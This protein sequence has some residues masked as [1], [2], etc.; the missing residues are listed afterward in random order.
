MEVLVFITS[1]ENQEQVSEVN[2]LLT[3]VPAITDW[4][5]DLD[6]CD[7][8]LRIEANDIP[9]GYIESLLQAAGFAC[10]ELHY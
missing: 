5:F 8:I 7:N 3:A 1:I 9:P 2:P 4:N 6:D 10:R